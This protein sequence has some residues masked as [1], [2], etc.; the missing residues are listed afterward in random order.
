MKRLGFS[1][2]FCALALSLPAAPQRKAITPAQASGWAR[3]ALDRETQQAFPDLWLSDGQGRRVPFLVERDDLWQPRELELA[4]LTVG[5]DEQGRPTLE[6]SLKYPEGWSVRQRE[7]LRIALEVEGE[8][9]WVCQVLVNRRQ[10][11]S[12]FIQLDGP[13]PLHVFDLG[14][15]GRRLECSVPWDAKVYRITLQAVQGR[16]PH[17]K[18]LRVTATTQSSERPE[19]LTLTPRLES[20][21][22]GEWKLS[23]EAADRLVGAQITLQP[24]A[25]P[26][27]PRFHLAPDPNRP[28]EEGPYVSVAGL[29]W[30]LPALH[31]TGTRVA[32]GPVT[33]QELRLHLPEGAVPAS[34]QLLARR[35][36]LLFPAEAGQTYYLHYG[37]Q[38]LSAPGDLGAL[39]D[40]SRDI[41]ARAPLS[42]GT[43]EADPHGVPLATPPLQSTRP[44]LPW[45]A[46]IA[47]LILGFGAWKLFRSGEEPKESV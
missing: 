32:L 35:D 30:N 45:V 9:P 22:K 25:A 26:L 47:V 1:A 21:G 4:S 15:A 37:G 40:S 17:L 29:L 10:E 20:L 33:A 6:F 39:P 12:T 23:L 41:Y 31:S 42:L 14:E 11:G 44:W 27:R 7:Q 18:G 19:D 34:V 46:G 24:P 13:A 43:A 36:V 16:A 2:L 8:G 38:V 3:L 5:K 28:R